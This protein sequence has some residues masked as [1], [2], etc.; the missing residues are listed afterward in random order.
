M[1]LPIVPEGDFNAFARVS[2]SIRVV[3]PRHPLVFI[4]T[5]EQGGS[6]ADDAGG[7]GS[8]QFYGASRDGFRTFGFF[9]KHQHWLSKRRPLFL[10][11][12]RIGEDQISPAHEIDEG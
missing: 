12:A 3:D 9:P 6:L 4:R 11:A 10:D 2:I 1:V 8:H 5:I 7:V